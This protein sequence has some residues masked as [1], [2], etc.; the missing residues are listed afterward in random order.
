M[1]LWN[2][3]GADSADFCGF[4]FDLIHLYCITKYFMN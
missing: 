3:D 1:N 2:A 4:Y